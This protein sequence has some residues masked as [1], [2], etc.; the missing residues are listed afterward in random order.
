MRDILLTLIIVGLLP[1]CF[2]RPWIGALVWAWL[3]YMNPHKLT[4]GFAYSLPFAQI[5]A[6]ATLAGLLFTKDRRPLPKVAEV[7]LLLVLLG[8]FTIS[9]LVIAVYPEDAWVLFDPIWKTFLMVFVSLLL[10]QDPQRLRALVLV[11]ALSIGYFGLKGGV[12]A[13]LTGG[14]YRV[15]GPP[16]SALG[17]NNA[18]A[19]ALNMMLPF[20]FFLRQAEERKWMRHLW[21][22]I[23]V[24]SIIAVVSSYSRGAILGLCVVLMVLVFR[25]KRIIAGTVL[26]ALGIGVGLMTLP[27]KWFGRMETIQTY[28]QDNSANLRFQS[29]TLAWRIALDKPILGGG[30][31]IFDKRTYQEYVPEFPATGNVAHN[32]FLQILAEHGFFGLGVYVVLIVVCMVS[33]RRLSNRARSDPSIAWIGRYALMIEVG[34]VGYVVTGLF[35]SKSYFD[36]FYSFVAM[37]ILLKQLVLDHERRVRQASP[38]WNV[39]YDS[40]NRSPVPASDK[41]VPVT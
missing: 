17:D 18:I 24:F 4:W 7:Y 29:W 13:V 39:R 23:F 10:L 28:E 30:F 34:M 38:G 5:V 20:F 35:V 16:E 6:V 40:G 19:L 36:L 9:P 8:I 22:A 25:N 31:A 33:L 41:P 15:M 14:Q 3:G 1:F 12:W 11:I 21:L 27:D 37:T 32:N 26:L 2:T